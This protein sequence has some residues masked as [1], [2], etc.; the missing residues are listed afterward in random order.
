MELGQ[1]EPAP[2]VLIYDIESENNEP[3]PDLRD[4]PEPSQGEDPK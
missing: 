2:E 1:S 3:P 4:D